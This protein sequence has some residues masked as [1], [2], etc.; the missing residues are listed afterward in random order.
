MHNVITVPLNVEGYEKRA[1]VLFGS[2]ALLAFYRDWRV[3][4]TATCVIGLDHMVRGY[5]RPESVF[6][7]S[8]VEPW[9][10]LEHV[11]WVAFEDIFL[12]QSCVQNTAEMKE[13]ALRQ[14]QL[15]QVNEVA[16]KLFGFKREEVL[17]RSFADLPANYDFPNLLR[18]IV[19][20]ELVV[21]EECHCTRKDGSLAEVA[22]TVSAL[23][24]K[25]GNLTGISVIARDI[26]NKKEAEK[27]ISEFYSTI[28]HELRTPLTSIRGAL[29]LMDDGAVDPSGHDGQ[30]LIKIAKASSI[31]LIRLINEI[32]D[33]RKIE[34][35]KL[36][37]HMVPLKASL[38][39]A[40][41][42]AAMMGMAAENGVTIDTEMIDDAEVLADA[43]RIV[44]VLIN[45][46]SNAI[47]FSKPGDTVQLRVELIEHSVRFSVI[48][49]GPGIPEY[50][51][52]K[53]FGRFQQLDSSDAREEKPTG[54]AVNGPHVLVVE[55]DPDLARVIVQQLGSEGIRSHVVATKM[56]CLEFLRAH[57]PEVILLD[58]FLPDG[59]GLE[60]V[61]YLR[62]HGDLQCVPI[63]V[64]SGDAS[65]RDYALPL[66]FEFMPK[67]FDRETL[68][69][70]LERAL[71]KVDSKRLLIVDDD[72]DTRAVIAAQLKALHVRTQQCAHCCERWWPPSQAKLWRSRRR[73]YVHRTS[74]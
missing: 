37:L 40:N 25:S 38:M 65:Q 23:R 67:P 69:A 11:A 43:D 52:S 2:L 55:D 50:D 57:T 64:M 49:E 59:N 14:A 28:S 58:L 3:L 66:V 13:I 32:L 70:A 8:T 34:S 41:A 71:G 68:L 1:E 20:G 45:L 15:E 9:R 6:G 61:D 51:Q 72:F 7:V 60:I 46:V 17:G 53:L 44:Q 26:T 42:A 21:N 10:W 29:S 62:N 33:L 22:M 30:E 48:D 73:R 56:D 12:I 54:I 5:F 47:K 36:P 31:R 24:D 27:R 74:D 18:R 63:I 4:V 16:S 19:S 39:V 35:G